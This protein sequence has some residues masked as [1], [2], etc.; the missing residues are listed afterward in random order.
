MYLDKI[1][2]T[3]VD[4]VVMKR[5]FKSTSI[6]IMSLSALGL[7]G[8][9]SA[10]GGGA[11]A[12]GSGGSVPTSVSK[13]ITVAYPNW[14]PTFNKETQA[15]LQDAEKKL[16]TQYPNVKIK[17]VPIDGSNYYTKLALMMRSSKTAPDV[18][19]EDSFKIASDAQAGYIQPMN[20]VKNWSG[21]QH[22]YPTMQK[23]VTYNGNV[24]GVMNQTD[25]QAIYYDTKIFKQVGLPVPWQPK[26]WNDIL[27][28]AQKIKQKDNSVTPLWLYAGK[29]QGETSTLRGFE[30]FLAGTKNS[31]YDYATKK[32]VTGGTGFNQTWNLLQKVHDEG[33][34][35]PEADWSNTNATSILNMQLMPKQQVGIAFDGIWIG[36]NYTAQSTNPWPNAFS[37]YKVAEIPTSNGQGAGTTN[38]SGGWALSVASKGHNPVLATKFIEAACGKDVLSGYVS[39][40]QELPPRDDMASTPSM[41][42]VFKSNPWLSKGNELLKNT[43]YRPA[44]GPQYS[45]ISN[46]IADLTGQIA[47]G[48]I[49]AKQAEQQYAA[50]VKSAAGSGNVESSK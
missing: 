33:L 3:G 32:W 10:S 6:G 37:A 12:N 22:F 11:S 45:Q 16:Q 15:W 7:V 20:D 48:S 30:V 36:Q 38:V 21:W 23:M 39:Q 29:P 49:T 24:Y 1:F 46:T 47:M 43:T 17:M 34:M 13:T 50:A 19:Y 14:T 42:K 25:A 44:V 8:C 26:N 18:V 2:I 41:Q 5:R 28:A 35:E 31:I 4:R 40:I 9:G 27:A